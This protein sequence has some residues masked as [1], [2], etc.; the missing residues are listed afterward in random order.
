MVPHVPKGAVLNTRLL[1]TFALAARVLADERYRS[2]AD[3][4]YDYLKDYFWDNEQGGIYWM[5]DYLGVPLDSKKQTYAQAFA[6]YALAEYYR[7]TSNPEVL[8]QAISLFD[9]VEE[10]TVDEA[11]GGYYEAYSRSWER[12]QDGR[13]SEKDAPAAKSSNTHLHVMEAYTTLYRV[14]P[15][16]KLSERLRALIRCFLDVI[17]DP[18]THQMGAAFN[19]QWVSVS[20]LISYGHDIEASWLLV[21]AAEVLGDAELLEEVQ[22]EALRMAEVVLKDGVDEDGGLLNE[23]RPSGFLDD[24]KHWWPQAEALVGF[25]NA[26]QLSQDARFLDAALKN[27]VFIQNYIIDEKEGEWYFRVSRQGVPYSEED[28]VGPWKAPYHNARAC[29]ELIHRLKP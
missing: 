11:H 17:I 28:K 15:S 24:D 22:V 3:R 21:E 26:Y 13:L 19:E 16:D 2:L 6:I 12:L 20:D 27:W 9:V 18:E 25:I 8:Q 5:L 4:A 7:L 29:L 1:W 10:R 23:A 14:W